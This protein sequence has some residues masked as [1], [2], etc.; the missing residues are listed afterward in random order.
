MMMLKNRAEK[1]REDFIEA[2]VRVIARHGVEG[3][4]TRRIAAEANAPLA[5]LHYYY[6]SKEELFHSIYEHLVRSLGE[7][8]WS[9]RRGAGLGRTA[10]TL[11][12]QMMAWYASEPGYAQTQQ[13]IF[14][15]VYR[16][17]PAVA[18]NIYDVAFTM[19]ESRLR[20]GM[21]PDDDENLIEPLVRAI[22]A[23]VDGMA[24]QSVAFGQ[25]PGFVATTI[26][27]V[28]QSMEL[29]ADSHRIEISSLEQSRPKF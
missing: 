21:R 4:T 6:A 28:G 3:A 8:P 12:R 20:E 25:V 26:D 5:S 9:V 15:W 13:E 7:V 17:D 1:R 23:T 29:L 27:A 14:F 2:A 16:Q 19:L 10:A 24:T 18:R 11:L 22:S